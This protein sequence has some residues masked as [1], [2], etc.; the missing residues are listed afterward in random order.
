MNEPIP[1]ST[2]ALVSPT[3][4]KRPR[5]FYWSDAHNSY[6]PLEVD[7]EPL[8][9]AF[10]IDPTVDNHTCSLC[11][12]LRIFNMSDEEMANLPEV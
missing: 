1:E 10:G 8:F 5:L 3:S 4:I 7:N 11:P 6:M 9:R 2:A 12:I